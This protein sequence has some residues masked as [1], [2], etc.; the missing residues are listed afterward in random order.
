LGVEFFR[1]G[2]EGGVDFVRVVFGEGG[3]EEGSAI[4]GVVGFEGEGV[5][6]V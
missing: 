1:N 3:D 4:A 6:R 5:R 2:L